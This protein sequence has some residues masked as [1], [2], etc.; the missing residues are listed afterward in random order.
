MTVKTLLLTAGACS[1]ALAIGIASANAFAQAQENKQDDKTAAQDKGAEDGQD[2]KPFTFKKDCVVNLHN[3]CGLAVRPDSGDVF[4][5]DSAA[6]RILRYGKKLGTDEYEIV[7]VITG[8]PKD[9]YGTGPMYDIGPL[10]LLF[11]DK[12]T[13]VVGGGG[14]KDG[15]ELLRFYTLPAAGGRITADQMKFTMGPLKGAD[16]AHPGE[17]N[18]YALAKAGNAIFAT[19]NGDDTKGW[20]NRCA[21]E[22]GEPKE[23]TTFIATKEATQVDAPVGITS[24]ADGKLLYVG[25][26]GEITVPAD[27]LLTCYEAETGKLLWNATTGRFDISA[28]AFNPK[29]GTLYCLDYGWMD[30]KEN[31]QGGL[32]RLDITDGEEGKKT[33]TA[34]KLD[35]LDRPTAMAFNADGQLFVTTFGPGEEGSANHPGHLYRYDGLK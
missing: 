11:L 22:N 4:I 14:N 28:L 30:T 33:V 34:T 24:D 29:S 15:A 16:E 25:Q 19:S 35:S 13:L 7:E 20:I 2:E 27:S 32:Y 8:F 21:L 10:G 26:M 17:G 18:F 6:S 1:L 12:D 23:Y 31:E 9:V 3:P 5:S